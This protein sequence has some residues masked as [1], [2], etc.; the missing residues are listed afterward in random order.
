MKYY[1]MYQISHGMFLTFQ[2]SLDKRLLHTNH[3]KEK[4]EKFEKF[5]PVNKFKNKTKET[6]IVCCLYVLFV[7]S[8]SSF[9]KMIEELKNLDF[10]EVSDFKQKILN[11]EKYIKI[12]IKKI[13]EKGFIT[14]EEIINLYL[15]NEIKFYT[16]YFYLVFTNQFEDLKKSR[17]YKLIYKKLKFIML[18]LT[19]KEESKQKI[20]KMIEEIL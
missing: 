18:F 3:S 11:Y 7:K 16:L 12:D 14:K 20:K 1:N 15:K 17:V 19:F 5:F 8:P 9:H 2:N 4:I 13:K 6:F 10:S